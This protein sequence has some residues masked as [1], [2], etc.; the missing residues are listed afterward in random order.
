MFWTIL[1]TYLSDT[2]CDDEDHDHCEC[3]CFD[4]VDGSD[5]NDNDNHG[6]SDFNANSTFNLFGHNYCRDDSDLSWQ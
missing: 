1:H 2:A 4:D 3:D 5:N 6:K